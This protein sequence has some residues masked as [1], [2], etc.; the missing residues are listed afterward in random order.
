L[1]AG[2]VG[3]PAVDGGG[4]PS[5]GTDVTYSMRA[6][7]TNV[8]PGTQLQPQLVF[9]APA[10]WDVVP[11]SAQFTAQ[12]SGATTT[13][14]A[15]AT[16]TYATR[17]INGQSR[18]V[19]VVTWPGLVTPSSDSDDYLPTLSV[20]ARPTA[21]ALA[22]TSVSAQVWAGDQSGTWRTAT[23]N[24]YLT[25]PTD[26]R[27]VRS[28][29]TDAAD[30]DGDADTTE[31][32]ASADSPGVIVAASSG[33]RVL[34][35]LCI[36]DDT[37]A[38]GCHWVSDPSQ[39]YGVP[40]DATNIKYRITL[41][42]TGNTNLQDVV[43]YDVL[44]YPG[45]TGLLANPPARGSQFSMKFQS[46]DSVS[47]GLTLAY[48][49]S[50][51]PARPEVDLD[52]TGTVDDW[53]PDI[54]GKQAIRIQVDGTLAGG[55]SEQVTFLAAVAAGAQADEQACNTAA[56]D[57]NATLPVEPLAVCVKLAEADLELSTGA[58]TPW[59]PDGPAT[60]PF[61]IVNHGGSNHVGAT[62]TLDVASGLRV[63]D[64]A[65]SGWQCTAPGGAPAPIDGPATLT[66]APVDG[67][68]DPRTLAV[69]DPETLS[70]AVTPTTASATALCVGAH[71]AG[72]IFDPDLTN[73]D[74]SACEMVNAVIAVD[75]TDTTS[76]TVPV[77]TDVRANDTSESGTPLADP[78]VT[79]DAGHGTASVDT[80]TGAI[81]YTPAAGFSGVDSYSYRVCDTS[82]PIPACD[83]ATVTV[84]VTNAFTTGTST[85]TPQ[86]TPVTTD[87]NDIASTTGAPLDPTTVVE[88]TAPNHGT[89]SINPTT[90]A[91][92][93]TPAAN[94]TGPDSYV[95][96]VCDTPSPAVQC[97]DATVQVTVG[98]NVVTAGDDIAVTV[99]ETAVVISVLGNDTVTQPVGAPLDPASV[100]ITGAA[101][102]GVTTIDDST[103]AVT[104]LPDDAW[105]G[106]DT[107]DYQVCDT[108]AP[109]VV[110]DT[111]TVTIMVTSAFSDGG[112]FTTPH[113]TALVLQLAEIMNSN[114]APLD[115]DSL[116][117]SEPPSHGTVTLDG[118]GQLTYTPDAGYTGPDFFAV[119]ACDT[120]TPTA[121]CHLT[122]VRV[123]VGPNTVTA[124][125]DTDTTGA[126]TAVTTDVP[127]ND[128]TGS[129][130]TPLDPASVT[131]A[132]RPSHGTASVDEATGAITYTPDAQWSGTD[133]Y[134][135][136]VCDTS[137]PTPVCDD[138]TVTITVDNVFTQEP[139][140][141]DG[142]ETLQN[143]PITTALSDIVSALGRPV[144]PATVTGD[145][146][147]T[148]GAIAIDPTTG[149]VTYTPAPG[150]TGPDSYAVDVCDKSDPVQCTSVPVAV[151]VLPN[152]VLVRD[153]TVSTRADTPTDP[154]DVLTSAT[155]ASGQPLNG[156]TVASEPEHGSVTVNA[157]GT[158]TY[159]PDDGYT[160]N[161][162]FTFSVCDTGRP[163]QACDTGTVHVTVTPVADL[164]VAKTAES[165][166]VAVGD[167]DTFT[168]TV[169]N[170]GPS[171]A[172]GVVVTDTPAGM[173]FVSADASQ[174][175]FDDRTGTWTVGTLP[176]G[177]TVTL[178][179][180]EKIT[181]TDA[182]NTAAITGTD[183][184]DPNSDN[185]RAVAAL[186]VSSPEA[187]QTSGG[188]G[189]L[190]STGSDV[191]GWV[192]TGLLLL[193][194]GAGALALARRRHRT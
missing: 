151:T 108:S 146:A 48:S 52:A 137:N 106:V 154:I 102:H 167:R 130:P 181:D 175:D 94:Y 117:S 53:G 121:Q 192:G 126:G 164:A 1:T 111:A 64:L 153:E 22:G 142:I 97:A 51:N 14:P 171:V 77:S 193:L 86:N 60:V 76:A 18:Q 50:T 27:A 99:P 109:T 62:V 54:T 41:E 68:G 124:V 98:A 47:D 101:A 188:G 35:E 13:A 176:V 131:I 143:A 29:V 90:G 103:G 69:D 37:A 110:C 81:T 120:S 17:T 107:F 123:T 20:T 189:A 15:G 140:A 42:N 169:V 23:G 7:M 147:P 78:T 165:A 11:G 75:D 170:H 174:G 166:K 46:I 138:A 91:V 129:A 136:T 44:P 96:T 19:V 82:T 168:V 6:Q 80:A 104:Y 115:P 179:V 45:D 12:G 144:D 119:R 25:N 73:N 105:S 39:V 28:A 161:D 156:P 148:H 74:D 61:H 134:G 30:V 71:I 139:A 187:A 88:T 33:L 93:Y 32:F 159:T 183:T 16:F 95:V 125:D 145:T 118:G 180:V 57:S 9:L 72:P 63:T 65:P 59:T 113:D 116:Q 152:T 49:A 92:T 122:P 31:S 38:D 66:C 67:S 3:N 87:L 100:T 79:T 141:S 191:C 184:P 58:L 190:A 194:L 163:V 162:S 160:G 34:K 89:I 133:T 36:P 24:G 56:V 173:E 128:S 85:G 55:T 132:T 155:S 8:W 43:A 177:Q 84:T 172:T 185:D 70:L 149:A 178:T 10:G 26:F 2:F 114:G 127:A 135:Y 158:L 40:V 83:T 4:N 157:D 182:R 112:P 186:S 5:V 150:Y 21:T